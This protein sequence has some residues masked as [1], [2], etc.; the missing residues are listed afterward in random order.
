VHSPSVVAVAAVAREHGLAFAEAVVLADAT[1]TLV[2][3]APTRVLARVATSPD[4]GEGP[5]R[6]DRELAVLAHLAGRGAPVV[7]PADELPPGPHER[8]GL[9]FVFL[10]HYERTGPVPQLEA[11][12]ALRRVHDELAGYGGQ[13]P[14]VQRLFDRVDALLPAVDALPDGPLLRRGHARLNEQLAAAEWEPRP[15]HG[16]AH[17]DNVMQTADGPRWHDFE[18]ACLGPLEYDLCW[19]GIAV[20][21]AY[22]PLD[23]RLAGLCLEHRALGALLWALPRGARAEA[24]RWLRFL[25]ERWSRL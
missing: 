16:D 18:A 20:R 12:R 4:A 7:A 10:R 24:D 25:R 19:F 3:L 5:E 13:L 9:R 6:I 21:S 23:E 11:G 2:H 22:G 8:D 15:L 1:N 17:L 14:P